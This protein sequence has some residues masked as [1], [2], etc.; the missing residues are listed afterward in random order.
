MITKSVDTLARRAAEVVS[1]RASLLALGGAAI[2]AATNS[3][4]LAAKKKKNCPK[5]ENCTKAND[6]RCA[7]QKQACERAMEAACE[8]LVIDPGPCFDSCRPCCESLS[9]C[10]PTESTACL[11]ACVS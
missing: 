1:R 5:C 9:S 6:D 11:M 7:A 3:T 2:S 4:T 10:D 8:N